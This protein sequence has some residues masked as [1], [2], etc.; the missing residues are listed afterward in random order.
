VECAG[1]GLDWRITTLKQDKN[2]GQTTLRSSRLIDEVRK[3]KSKAA[4]ITS[5][6]QCVHY[7]R[8]DNI[9]IAIALIVNVCSDL[10]I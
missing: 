7:P 1:A 9:G 10:A 2:R 5:P 8:I 3:D 4:A 6:N